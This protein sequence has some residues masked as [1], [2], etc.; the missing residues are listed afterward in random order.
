ML[1]C[2]MK[3]FV[4]FLLNQQKSVY[5]VMAQYKHLSPTVIS[6]DML[7]PI[8]DQLLM[9]LLV[10]NKNMHSQ[11]DKLIAV[12]PRNFYNGFRYVCSFTHNCYTWPKVE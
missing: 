7:P 12:A 3:T 9:Q 5:R 6:Y 2:K 10:P 1:P 4:S 11:L 8:I